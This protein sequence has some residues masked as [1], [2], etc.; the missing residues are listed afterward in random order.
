MS[1]CMRRLR[2]R[3]S[4]RRRGSEGEERVVHV[5]NCVRT[6]R[7]GLELPTD[8]NR[9]SGG[10]GWGKEFYIKYSS[11]QFKGEDIQSY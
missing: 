5:A 11:C 6:P 9:I 4:G 2:S 10:R 8:V 7:A 3:I 1:S